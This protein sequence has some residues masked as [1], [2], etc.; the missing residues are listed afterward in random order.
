MMGL[1]ADP[2]ESNMASEAGPKSSAEN[3]CLIAQI[4]IIYIFRKE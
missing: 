1:Q 3:A 2:L 4:R